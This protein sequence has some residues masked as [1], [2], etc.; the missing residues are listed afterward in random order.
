MTKHPVHIAYDA[1][2]TFGDRLADSMASKIGSWPFVFIQTVLLIAWLFYNGVTGFLLAA[3]AKA[4][5]GQPFD[6][7]PFIL[8]NLMLSFQAA[9]TGPI[10]LISAN[11]QAALDRARAEHDLQINEES[12]AISERIENKVDQLIRQKGG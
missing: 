3:I 10:L 1:Q 4:T 9:Y 5:T 11:R 8:L 6:A 7:A 12:L 2:R